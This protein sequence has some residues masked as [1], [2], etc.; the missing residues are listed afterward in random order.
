ML[1][2]P[3]NLF[4]L[5]L[6]LICSSIHS[7]MPPPPNVFLFHYFHLIKFFKFILFFYHLLWFMILLSF[8]ISYVIILYSYLIFQIYIWG[9]WEFNIVWFCLV[10]LILIFLWLFS[11]FF[12][13][14]GILRVY[15][16]DNFSW[17]TFTFILPGTMKYLWSSQFH[18]LILKFLV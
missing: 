17:S 13:S 18:N 16:R 12:L 15:L 5:Q 9:Q 14:V 4:S 3:D 6:Y 10:S 8:S 11:E 7:L 1:C 2:I